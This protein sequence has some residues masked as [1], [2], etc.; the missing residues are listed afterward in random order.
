MRSVTPALLLLP[1]FLA[2]AA[3]G[4]GL[5]DLIRG[6]YELEVITVTDVNGFRQP[7]NPDQPQYYVAASLGYRDL[8]PAIPGFAEPPPNEAV[9]HL[10]SSELAKQGYLP[11]TP[12]SAPP[13]LLLVYTW[14]TLNVERYSGADPSYIRQLN[15]G[16]LVR[17]L[18]GANVGLGQNFFDSHTAPAPG[19]TAQSYAGQ[20]IYDVAGEDL[21]VFAVAAYD[22]ADAMELKRQPPVWTTRIALPSLG[23][24]FSN[25]FPTM[26]AIGGQHFGRHTP[27]PVWVNASDKFKP[28]VRL[29]ELQLLEYLDGDPLPVTDASD[30][31]LEHK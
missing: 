18:G 5:W 26:L 28:D 13:T 27:A 23:F 14:G 4:A 25:V 19:L 3:S 30:L 12:L 22:Y 17:F 16:Q 2:P 10:L 20:R 24:S 31:P 8:G 7:A 21:F 11:A 29:G 15:R 6:R 9:V 1:L